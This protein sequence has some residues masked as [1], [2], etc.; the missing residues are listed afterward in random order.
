VHPEVFCNST[1]GVLIAW[2]RPAVRIGEMLTGLYQTWKY[3]PLSRQFD[4]I[5]V[6]G[7][8]I[9]DQG[10]EKA[11]YSGLFAFFQDD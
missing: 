9:P 11:I 8:V 2:Y 10:A 4:Q 3:Q 7:T 5:A 1:G 6:L